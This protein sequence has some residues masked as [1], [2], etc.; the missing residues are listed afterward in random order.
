M[1]YSNHEFNT[2][3]M[4]Y[5]LKKLSYS[6]NPHIMTYSVPDS[7]L[8]ITGGEAQSPKT[9]FRPFGPQFGLEIRRGGGHLLASPLD[10]PLLAI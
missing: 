5:P 4:L 7:D 8:E 2:I 10:P 6:K 9:F 3:N 1:G